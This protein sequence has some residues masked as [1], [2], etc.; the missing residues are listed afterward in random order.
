[1]QAIAAAHRGRRAEME[2]LTAQLRDDPAGHGA[3]MPLVHGLGRAFSSLLDVDPVGARRELHGA[4]AVG[5]SKPSDCLLGPL[6]GRYG[7]ALL[8]DVLAGTRGW[9]DYR[10]IAGLPAA[11]LRWNRH[12]TELAQA[13]LLGRDGSGELASTALNRAADAGAIYPT[14]KQLGMLLVA[15]EAHA[16]GWGQPVQ[17]LR[18]AEDHF[19]RMG[20]AAA[21]SSCRRLQRDMGGRLRQR[22]HGTGQIPERLRIAGVTARELEV[23]RLLAASG[24]NRHIASELYLSPRTVERHVA[25][26]LAKTGQANRAGLVG[27]YLDCRAAG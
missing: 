25:N 20:H 19:F 10:E 15:A 27:Y 1:L 2:T 22:R 13:V 3:S 4:E 14:A 5:G 6:D 11:R 7:L 18:V 12:F 26:L 16:R 23:L 17:W 21:V 8:L 24:T 9:P